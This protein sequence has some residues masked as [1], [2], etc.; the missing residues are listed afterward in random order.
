[1]PDMRRSEGSVARQV[2][3]LQVLVV[4]VLVLVALGLAAYD[5]RQDARTSA[6]DR[7]LGP[8]HVGHSAPPGNGRAPP[9]RREL[10]EQNSDRRHTDPDDEGTDPGD[11]PGADQEE[12]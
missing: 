10:N 8:A 9:S 12:P 7:A 1:M 3:G 5:A 11:S 2:F 4:V 6:S